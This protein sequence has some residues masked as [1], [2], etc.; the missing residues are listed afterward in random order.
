M[1][2]GKYCR[3]GQ[4]TNGRAGPLIVTLYLTRDATECMCGF[5]SSRILPYFPP[6]SVRHRRDI[7]NFLQIMMKQT[8]QT[9]HFLKAYHQ[10]CSPGLC[11]WLYVCPSMYQRECR[12]VVKCLFAT[13]YPGSL[14]LALSS[15]RLMR[16]NLN[17]AE[18]RVIQSTTLFLVG[19]FSFFG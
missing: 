18:E 12:R 4:L 2:N 9:I 19:I 11:V 7:T 10:S 15:R 14:P 13:F 5:W 6:S 1:N 17:Q 8:K 16:A 3:I